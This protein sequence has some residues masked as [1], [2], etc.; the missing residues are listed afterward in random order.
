MRDALLPRPSHHRHARRCPLA[1][2]WTTGLFAFVWIGSAVGQTLPPPPVP[3]A[4]QITEAKRVL[5][6]V[7]FW[8]EQLSSDNTM[9]CGSCHSPGAG[10]ADPRR[11][12]N[13][14]PDA[15]FNSP[16]DI[17]GSPG[18]IRSDAAGNYK[19]DTTFAFAT[20]VTGRTSMDFGMAAYVQGGGAFWDG[21]ARAQFIDPQTNQVV[22]N[23]GGALESQSV[24]P[25]MSDVEMA[26]EGRDWNQVAAK[27]AAA[28]PLALATNIPPDM[29]AAVTA[30][31][32]YA[33]LFQNAFGSPQITASRMAQAIATYE[34][35][36]I[37]NDTPW[38][39][40]IAGQQNAMTQGQIQGWNFFR[41]SGCSV[42]HPA[43]VFSNQTFRN[44]GVRPPDED[45]GR[46]IVT[47]AAADRG[48]FKVPSLRNVGLRR[49]LMHNG[50]FTNVTDV[51]HFYRRTP[52]AAP[53]FNDNRDPAVPVGVPG[54]VVNAL[55]DFLNNGLTDA[56]ARDQAFPFD[57]PTLFSQRPEHQAEN[58]GG[59]TA[60]SGGLI[61]QVL[62]ADPAFVG[63]ANFR[64]GLHNARGGA[65]A[66]LILSQ[67]PPINGSLAGQV[68]STLV[69][70]GAGNGTGVGT[71][72]WPIGANGLLNGRTYFAQWTVQDPAAPGG[73]ARS[74]IV[75]FTTFCAGLGCP[76]S[77]PGD[78]NLDGNVTPDDLADYIA[79]YF[80]SPS[81]GAD[82]NLDGSTNPDDLSDFIAAYFGGCA[83]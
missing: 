71:A 48:R 45:L 62:L 35:T 79:A 25:P 41:N 80:A 58:L 12:R 23:A 46:Q 4:N 36:V 42:C 17:F 6:K 20:Q 22:L 66:S 47:N 15:A 60:G 74:N 24:G 38:D 16:D 26:H 57:R 8:D 70:S 27:L 33:E 61:P 32:T 40:F 13:P 43:P 69:L 18:V 29:L 83:A 65:Q 82:F 59:G 3:Q 11:V 31:P 2:C 37:P 34:R 77:C 67:T 51:I 78:Y 56:R 50:Q 53:M 73:I 55:A 49:S 30:R 10:G 81:T 28:R 68:E 75:R 39:R 44:I 72:H 76:P 1:R 21:R 54:N 52:G 7:L 14:G 19:R 63:N 64:I 9:S 5:G